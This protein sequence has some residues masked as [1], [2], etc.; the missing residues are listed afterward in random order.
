MKLNLAP[1]GPDDTILANPT[2]MNETQDPMIET[3]P[4]DALNDGMD[5]ENHVNMFLN[6]YDIEM[7]TNSSK[8]KRC[9]EGKE[10]TSYAT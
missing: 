6:L 2:T 3:D 10:A 5:V 7:S 1:L 4:L 8:K 9:E